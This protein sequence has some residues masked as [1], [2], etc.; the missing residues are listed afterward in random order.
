[1][2]QRVVYL[3]LS[4]DNYATCH[5]GETSVPDEDYVVSLAE[6]YDLKGNIEC[7]YEWYEIGEGES[8]TDT[9]FTDDEIADMFESGNFV[10]ACEEKGYDCELVEYGTINA[11]TESED[12]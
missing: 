2:S 6:D 7:L 8:D 9:F 3:Q 12:E 5:Y 4:D 10:K 1:M 11:S